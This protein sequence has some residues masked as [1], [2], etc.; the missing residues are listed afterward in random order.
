MLKLNYLLEKR[1]CSLTSS[2]GVFLLVDSAPLSKKEESGEY[3]NIPKINLDETKQEV[4][5]LIRK[6]KLSDLV[7]ENLSQH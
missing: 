2:R 6:E 1:T 5:G 7:E 3:S 4:I